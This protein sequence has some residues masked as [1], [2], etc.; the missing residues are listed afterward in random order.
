M[1]RFVSDVLEGANISVLFHAPAEW[2]TTTLNSDL[3]REFFLVFKES[4]NNVIRHAECDQVEITFEAVGNGLLLQVR[5]NGK[6][7][8]PPKSD[9]HGH[10]LA[11][12]QERARRLGGRL[13]VYSVPGEGTI[14]RLTAPLIRSTTFRQMVF[15]RC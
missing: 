6:G 15:P 9:G 1:R 12:M 2:A 4:I 3:R 8:Q 10:G 14:V 7:F 13:E 11:S 5:D